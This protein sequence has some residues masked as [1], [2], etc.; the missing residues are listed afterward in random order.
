MLATPAPTAVATTGAAITTAIPTAAANEMS[1]TTIATVW[2]FSAACA[3][4]CR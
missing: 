1:R 2:T 4:P 3:N